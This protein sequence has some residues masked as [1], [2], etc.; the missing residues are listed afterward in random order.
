MEPPCTQCVDTSGLRCPE[1]VMMLHNALRKLAVGEVLKVIATD[2]TTERDVPRFCHYLGHEL[3]KASAEE[4]VYLYFIR[5][6]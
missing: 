2:P 6:G 5:R 4:G 1:P 3:V